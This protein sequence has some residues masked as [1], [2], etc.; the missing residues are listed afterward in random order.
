M[1][2]AMSLVRNPRGDLR[3]FRLTEVARQAA[4]PTP[5]TFHLSRVFALQ[6][7]HANSPAPHNATSAP[8][9]AA[10]VGCA[11]SQ[12]PASG[13]AK[14]GSVA[15]SVLAMETSKRLMA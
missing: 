6:A 8:I 9:T 3:F 15:S 4:P 12:M 2:G 11:R 5:F 1:L 7:L 14:T 13:K 10:P